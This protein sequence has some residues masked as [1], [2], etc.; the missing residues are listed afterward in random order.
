M[1]V[2]HQRTGVMRAC[3]SITLKNKDQA[4]LVETEVELMK[5]L[6]HPNILRLYEVAVKLIDFGLSE[7]LAKI[8]AAAKTVKINKEKEILADGIRRSLG[9]AIPGVNDPLIRKV[10]PKAGTPHYMPPE[11]HHKAWYGVKADVFACG[12]MLYQM[13]TGVHP[14]FIP[15]KDNAD[16]AKQKIVLCRVD[17]SMTYWNDISPLAKDLVMRMLAADPRDRV[18][19][20]EALQHLWFASAPKVSVEIRGSVV[21]NLVEFQTH[22]K[23]R[24]AVLRLLAKE[25][26]ETAI[27]DLR[28]QFVAMDGDGDGILQLAEILEAAQKAGINASKTE[29]EAVMFT[30]HGPQVHEHVDFQIGLNYRDFIGALLERKARIFST[31]TFCLFPVVAIDR[32][33]LLEIFK[34]FEDPND[35]GFITTASI[36]ESI[37]AHKRAPGA[38]ASRRHINA[39]DFSDGELKE[40]MNGST[41]IN[42]ETFLTVCY[43]GRITDNQGSGGGGGG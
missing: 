30:L 39:E 12:I 17:Y 21:D 33:H 40:I 3:K 5:Q 1:T 27:A 9:I 20:H 35:P 38:S 37:K 22:N 18:D 7:F 2:K 8:E 19:T 32:A 34:R 15:G 41:K 42:F 31:F 43:K 24:Q 16:S 28:A 26:D 4:R 14:F 11:M 36:K 10:M 6:D 29:L 13:L 25:V 23:L